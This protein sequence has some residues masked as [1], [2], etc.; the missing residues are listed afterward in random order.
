MFSNADI[1]ELDLASYHFIEELHNTTLNKDKESTT[2]LFNAFMR[3]IKH[4][5]KM[6]DFEL[7]NKYP[8]APT[9]LISVN[10]TT[11][12]IVGLTR[13][14]KNN[15]VEQIDSCAKAIVQIMKGNFECLQ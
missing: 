15:H 8:T 2:H 6:L 1:R 10:I 14:I 4:C 13:A 3:Y 9:S 12:W 7:L 5:E 11:Q